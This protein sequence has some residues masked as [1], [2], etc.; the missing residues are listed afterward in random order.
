VSLWFSSYSDRITTV[1]ILLGATEKYSTSGKQTTEW[2]AP[3]IHRDS[4]FKGHDGD[5][6]QKAKSEKKESARSNI[7]D[8]FAS[9]EIN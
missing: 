5:I 8:A 1:P 7:S 9:T 3:D 2:A 6:T 4:P